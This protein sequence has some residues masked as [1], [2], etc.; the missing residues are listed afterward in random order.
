[1]MSLLVVCGARPCSLP[2]RRDRELTNDTAH[3]LIHCCFR[4]LPSDL[5]PPTHHRVLPRASTLD[6]GVD[7]APCS[8]HAPCTIGYLNTSITLATLSHTPP[9]PLAHAD[10]LRDPSSNSLQVISSDRACTLRRSSRIVHDD[11]RHAALHVDRLPRECRSVLQHVA[12]G[13]KR[14]R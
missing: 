3:N 2:E 10:R 11:S 5:R 13:A 14:R 7:S 1:M 4:S 8:L 6:P 9:S 12:A